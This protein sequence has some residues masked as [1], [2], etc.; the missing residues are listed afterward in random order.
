[1]SKTAIKKLVESSKATVLVGVLA[2]LGVL[3][4]LG[5]VDAAWF[6]ET[7][8]WLIMTWMGAHAVEQSA[9]HVS[10][11]KPR[12]DNSTGIVLNNSATKDDEAD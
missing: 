4:Y 3:V 9:K 8:K 2:V 10:N 1:M 7:A 11:S 12:V 5:K 6:Q